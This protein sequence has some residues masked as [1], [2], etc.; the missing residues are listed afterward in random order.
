MRFRL[1]AGAVLAAALLAPAASAK[2]KMTLTL[3]DATPAAGQPVTVVMRYAEVLRPSATIRVIVV[4]PKRSWHDVVGAVTGGTSFSQAELP[5]DGF[6]V[7][8]TR[9]APH[10]WRGVVRFPRPGRWLVVVANYG[11]APGFALP[12]P[13]RR[14]VQVSPRPTL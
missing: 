7:K 3:G 8:L 13:I 9:V 6:A 11:D 5:R 12:P 10:R 14:P 1:L 4:A 2:G